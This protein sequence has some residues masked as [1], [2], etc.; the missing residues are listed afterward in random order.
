MAKTACPSN[1]FSLASKID[2]E[3]S[4]LTRRNLGTSEKPII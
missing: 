4:G 1:D 2:V 3:I